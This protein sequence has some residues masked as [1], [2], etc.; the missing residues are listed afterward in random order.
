MKNS[1]LSEKIMTRATHA[2]DLDMTQQSLVEFSVVST[3]VWFAINPHRF[4]EYSCFESGR[5]IP[6]MFSEKKKGILIVKVK[7]PS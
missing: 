6:K 5:T 1:D 2:L 4:S 3:S 7:A